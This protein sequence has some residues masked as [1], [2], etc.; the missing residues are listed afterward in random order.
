MNNIKNF[1][2]II[3]SLSY[4]TL[5]TCNTG[6]VFIL[7]VINTVNTIAINGSAIFA[8]SSFRDKNTTS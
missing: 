4:C 7:K 1:C 6:C 3:Y 8:S 2:S 5:H